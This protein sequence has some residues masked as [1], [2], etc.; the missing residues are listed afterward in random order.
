LDTIGTASINFKRKHQL[1][2]MVE[3]NMNRLVS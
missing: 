3:Y 1:L 2:Q